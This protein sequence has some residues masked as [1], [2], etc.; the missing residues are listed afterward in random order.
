MNSLARTSSA[1]NEGK[2]IVGVYA[3]G[4]NE[5]DVSEALEK[6]ANDVWGWQSEGIVNQTGRGKQ[7]L[8]DG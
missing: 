2:T 5:C 3:R 4:A 6:Y 7:G 1:V 8:L